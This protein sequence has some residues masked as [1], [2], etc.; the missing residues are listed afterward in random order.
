MVTADGIAEGVP[1]VTSDAIDW[2]PRRWEA[3]AD[4]ANDIADVGLG[5]LFNPQAAQDGLVA[6]KDHNAIGVAS[7]SSVLLGKA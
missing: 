1:S 4:D 5:L 2:V 7:W 3:S 6:L